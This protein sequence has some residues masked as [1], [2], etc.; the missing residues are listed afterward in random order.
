MS[1]LILNKNKSEASD[2]NTLIETQRIS[3]FIFLK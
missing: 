2:D 3:T 1:E